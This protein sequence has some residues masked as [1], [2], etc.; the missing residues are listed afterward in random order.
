MTIR[1]AKHD[2]D[3]PYEAALWIPPSYGGIYAAMV[4]DRSSNPLPYRVI[5]FGQAGNFSDR[6]FPYGHHKYSEWLAIAGS[7]WG[8][9]VATYGMPGST[10]LTR[11]ALERYLINY[12]QPVCNEVFTSWGLR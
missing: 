2:F 1:F 9:Y 12:Y 5:Y 11:V 6:G 8:L 7:D 10:E 4:Y 3:G